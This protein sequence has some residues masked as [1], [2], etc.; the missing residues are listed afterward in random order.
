M[1]YKYVNIFRLTV[2][3]DGYTTE[4][5][6]HIFL[7]TPPRKAT[8]VSQNSV[9]GEATDFKKKLTYIRMHGEYQQA[10]STSQNHQQTHKE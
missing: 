8:Q 1:Q 6:H 10:K 5:V 9:I 7:N 4:G 3:Y 2:S